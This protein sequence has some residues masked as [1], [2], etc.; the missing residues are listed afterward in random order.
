MLK[1][2]IFGQFY[3]V[4][5]KLGLQVGIMQKLNSNNFYKKKY[6]SELMMPLILYYKLFGLKLI[7]EKKKDV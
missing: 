3:V 7:K 5:F 2:N 1:K 6:K 4:I